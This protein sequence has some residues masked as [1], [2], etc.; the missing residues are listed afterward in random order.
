MVIRK[1]YER[2]ASL[3]RSPRDARNHCTML[4]LCR[5]SEFEDLRTKLLVVF[6][7]AGQA[8]PPL[9]PKSVLCKPAGW[10]CRN[11]GLTLGRR[12]IQAQLSGKA[13]NE[14]CVFSQVSVLHQGIPMDASERQQLSSTES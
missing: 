8:V 5:Y 4:T 3:W 7:H 9:P 10:Q 6:P 1:R 12:Q 11:T 14:S 13:K 2:P